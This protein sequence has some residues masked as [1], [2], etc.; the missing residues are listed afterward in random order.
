M[1]PVLP[2]AAV[3][4]CGMGN[5][6]GW[7][8]CAGS[9]AVHVCCSVAS[10][11]GCSPNKG[12]AKAVYV[13]VFF[14]SAILGIFLRYWGK[15]MLST[16]VAT[17]SSV[18]LTD[19]CW[20]YE[21]AYRVS[22]AVAVWFASLGAL[23]YAVPVTHLGG[24]LAKLLL[25]VLFLGLTLLI[26]SP[27][28]LQY[29]EAARVFSVLFLL[30]QVFIVLDFAYNVHEWLV[31]RMDKK[32]AEFAAQGWQPGV[33]S[34]PW[35]L[36]YLGSA[37]ALQIASLV[38]LGL[39]FRFFG[40]CALNNFFTGETLVVGLAMNALSMLGVVGRGLLP[41]SIIFAYNTVLAY[42]AITNNPDAGCNALA[43]VG[44]AS[45]GAIYGGLAVTALSVSWMA[46]SS[47]GSM[48]GAVAYGAAASPAETAAMVNPSSPVVQRGTAV[49]E[50]PTGTPKAAGAA[51]DYEEAGAGPGAGRPAHSSSPAGA[52]E[53]PAVDGKEALAFHITMCLGGMYLA[54]AVTNWGSPGSSNDP[55]GNPELSLASMWARIGSQF[56]IHVLFG[57]TLVAA[58]CCPNRTFS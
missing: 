39:L 17:V 31:A 38:G 1:L 18:C 57:W 50:W 40:T 30:A 44:S 28:I 41:P 8:C 7:A 14:I 33:C 19:A 13:G 46:F 45:P 27:S 9:A 2:A 52:D 42:Q 24:W 34:N 49:A 3:A 54:M 35:T 10:C 4:V 11:F 15:A 56:A 22:L 32:N 36:L 29:A 6:A 53:A 51:A 43:T 55:A 21:G 12:L 48:R 47:A 25:W 58:T 23:A 26:P 20:G 16:W 37:L 5:I